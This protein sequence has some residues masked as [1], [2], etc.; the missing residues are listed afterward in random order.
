MLQKS[1]KS[2]Y[3]I[4]SAGLDDKSDKILIKN[5]NLKL[6]T[7]LDKLPDYDSIIF[8]IGGTAW[9]N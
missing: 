8:S 2:M 5:D 4:Q 3:T 7:Y 6:Y 9:K 1:R